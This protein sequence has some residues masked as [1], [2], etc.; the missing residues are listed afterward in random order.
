MELEPPLDSSLPDISGIA[1]GRSG[2]RARR[3]ARQSSIG[4]AA[5]SLQETVAVTTFLT[6]LTAKL[7]YFAAGS[8]MAWVMFLRLVAY[9]AILLPGFLRIVYR[10]FTSTNVFREFYGGKRRQS[11]GEIRV[12]VRVRVKLFG[13]WFWVWVQCL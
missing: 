11:L 13:Y 5:E 8:A 2:G 6:K 7:M 1:Q 9:A 12:G 10:Y 3:L 4:E